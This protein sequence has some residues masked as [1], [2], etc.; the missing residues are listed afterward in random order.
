MIYILI[1]VVVI[2]LLLLWFH[3]VRK[4]MQERQQAVEVAA[5]EVERYRKRSSKKQ[6]DSMLAGVFVR[7]EDIY[8]QAVVLYQIALENP[9][10]RLPAT[11]MGFRPITKDADSYHR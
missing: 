11:L 6:N 3:K 10:N 9:F 5:E 7:S 8:K 2:I 1:L 4:I